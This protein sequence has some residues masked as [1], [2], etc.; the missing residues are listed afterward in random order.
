[1][2]FGLLWNMEQVSIL[3]EDFVESLETKKQQ[4]NVTQ[5]KRQKVEQVQIQ[6]WQNNLKIS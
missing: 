1:M 2:C 6:F 4:Q 5:M 3:K